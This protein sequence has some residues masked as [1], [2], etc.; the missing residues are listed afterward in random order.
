MLLNVAFWAAMGLQKVYNFVRVIPFVEC[1][2]A[3]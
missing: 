2:R 3:V 1:K